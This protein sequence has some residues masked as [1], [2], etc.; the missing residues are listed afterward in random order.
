MYLRVTAG[1]IPASV[2]HSLQYHCSLGYG[3]HSS[4]CGKFIRVPQIE[5]FASEH[6]NL[7]HEKR[8]FVL[9]VGI[10]FSWRCVS[11]LFHLVVACGPGL[12]SRI[13]VMKCSQCPVGTYQTSYG[14][15]DCSPCPPNQ[16][17]ITTGSTSPKQCLGIIIYFCPWIM[18][19]YWKR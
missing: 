15:G 19:N 1:L 11:F 8:E 7:K 18:P 12:Y 5:S 2:E 13:D 3:L 6:P 16:F 10:Y 14:A 4:L 9:F 17:T